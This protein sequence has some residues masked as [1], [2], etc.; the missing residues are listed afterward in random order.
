MSISIYIPV[1]NRRDEL[2]RTLRALIPEKEGSEVLVLDLGSTDGTMDVL[3]EFPWAK[4]LTA[5][6]G[7][8]AEAL[9]QA[10]PEGDGEILLFLEAGSLP[11]R[12]WSEALE[13]HFSTDADAGHL[14]CKETEATAPWAGALRSAAAGIGVQLLGGPS[15]LNGVAVRRSTFEK[16][17]GFRPVPD[18]EWL[19]FAARLK[20]AG[21][22]VKPVGHDLL[23]LPVAGDRQR[24]A[25]QDLKEDF[26]SAWRYRKNETFDP[27]RFKRQATVAVL[28][29]YDL[30]PESELGDYGGYA[31]E[32]VLRQNL[33]C[34]Q[35]YSGVEKIFFIGGSH[36]N[37]VLGQPS[38]VEVIGNPRKA[39]KTRFH[40]LLDRLKSLDT[41]SV[42][43][44]R[45]GAPGLSPKELRNL[46][47]S[48][49][50]APCLIISEKNNSREWVVLQ[51][52]DE[53]LAE[54]S[55]WEIEEAVDGLEALFA[56]K[57]I[58]HE[59]ESSLP[60]LR[61]DSDVRALYYSG[62]LQRLPA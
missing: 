61:T 3:S 29:G 20:Q 2:K 30:F 43:L 15:S 18:F 4:G 59:V 39:L 19:A 51:A 11:A 6:A 40:E 23:T 21:A 45:A 42:L 25:W 53:A 48:K 36:T 58:R 41:Q 9:N 47:R 54:L 37:S 26:L 10:V 32:E 27:E 50:E 33:E 24:D 13:T 34:L 7:L 38:G 8:R 28:F 1:F 17:E 14:R 57:V 44:V 55:N 49:S 46:A 31:R 60:L 35:A 12:G 62:V 52:R 56:P 22:K 5:K 16:V